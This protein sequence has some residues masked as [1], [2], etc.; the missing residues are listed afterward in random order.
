MPL[1]YNPS[2]TYGTA[3]HA[4]FRGRCRRKKF[5]PRGCPVAFGPT[6]F[7]SLFDSFTVLENRHVVALP[8]EH[9]LTQ[10]RE[11]FLRDLAG[12]SFVQFPRWLWPE[13]VD[14]IAQ[15][16][17]EAGFT[18]RVVQEAQPM[19]NLLNLVGR[20]FGVAIVP[21]P[22]CW[23][24]GCVVLKKIEDFDL[25]AAFQLTWLRNNRSE[26]LQEFVATTRHVAT[27][28][29][30]D[31]PISLQSNTSSRRRRPSPPLEQIITTSG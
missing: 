4:L 28:A 9:S 18:L 7:E 27:Q 20:G 17:T 29:R 25:P 14:A 12:E 30:S 24:S 19:H 6:L 10:K 23:P 2:A 3:P 26:I 5:H 11:I 31:R 16:C 21:D 1:G 13:R 15:K 8:S 22:I